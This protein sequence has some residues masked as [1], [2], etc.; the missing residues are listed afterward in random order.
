MGLGDTVTFGFLD[1]AGAWADTHV[2]AWLGNERA[3]FSHAENLRRNRA[4]LRAAEE[5]HFG[6]YTTGQVVG[7]FVPVLGWGGRAKAAYATAKAGRS[8]GLG[9][10]VVES[11]A[12]GALYGA[13]SADTDPD[14][15]WSE[16][17]HD[18]VR[19]AAIGG[20]FGAAGG[21]VLGTTVIP[22][23]RWGFDKATALVT[24]GKSPRL[25]FGLQPGKV[26][27]AADD[28]AENLAGARLARSRG[29]AESA[30]APSV[31]AGSA[32]V[33]AN[34]LTGHADDAL[35][36]GAVFTARELADGSASA[37]KTVLD[38]IAKLTPQEAR[39]AAQKL[40]NAMA[41]GDL[42]TDPHFRSLLGL[43]LESA[44]DDVAAALKGAEVFEDMTQ[45]LLQRAGMGSQSVKGME[46]RL[47]KQFGGELSESD[48]D[49]LVA[50]QTEANGAANVGSSVMALAGI[51][52][53]RATKELLP[54][55]MDG[56]AAAREALVE[57]LTSAIRIS[58]KGRFLVSS[59]GRNLGMLAH[60]R[61][62]PFTEVVG[63]RVEIESAEAI[64]AR[65]NE[66]LS[67]LDDAE[68]NELLS[69]VRDLSDLE[70]VQEVLLDAGAAESVS[71]FIKARNSVGLWIKSNSLTPMSGVVNVVGAIMHDLFRNGWARDFAA[72]TARLAGDVDVATSLSFQR[73]VAKAVHWQA[74]GAG[75][76][77]AINRLKWEWLDSVEKVAG[78]AGAQRV[79]LKASASRQ[80][81]VAGGYQPPELREFDRLRTLA[82][83]DVRGFNER[84][85]QRAEDGGGFASFVNGLER[86]YAAGINTFDALGTAT[87]RVVS[88]ALDDW[89]RNF[90]RVKEV[91]AASAAHAT[92]EAIEAGLNERQ[93]TEYVPKRA[94]EL[95]EL[96]PAD[97]L[98]EV[99]RKLVAGEDLGD[100]D[101]MLLRRDYEADKE[102]ERVLFMDGP[103]T[104]VGRAA[105]QAAKGADWVAG[106]MVLP[107]ILMTYI[108]TPTRIFERGLMS[109]TP[110]AHLAEESR[111]ALARGGVD[112]ALERARM[113]LGGMV[114]GIGM[115]AA[116]T[117]AITVTNGGYKNSRNLEGAPANRLNLPGGGYVELSR[118]D[119]FALT[120]A[121]GGVIGQAYRTYQEDGDEYGR[122]VAVAAAM[123]TAWGA[124]REAV[125]EKS[126]LTGAREL[127][128]AWFADEDATAASVYLDNAKQALTRLVPLA[129]TSR[130]INET[131]AGRATEAVTFMDQLFKVTPGMGLYLAPRIDALG[132]ETEGRDMGLAAGTTSDTDPLAKRVAALGIDIGNLRKSDP[133]GFDL[134][135]EELSELRRIRGKEAVNADGLTMPEALEALLD[136]PAFQA[137]QSRD[138]K[139]A[140]VGEV[141]RGFN[142]PARALFE[143]RN[144]AY[145]SDREARRSLK[146]YIAAGIEKHEARRQVRADVTGMGLPAPTRLA[147]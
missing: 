100:T 139:Q 84:L 53:A 127:V 92:R 128:K 33:R 46:A 24:R 124:V 145:L 49:R 96:P 111:A 23:A 94:A 110:W 35:E 55:V 113:D 26:G 65:V 125:L 140:E 37:R 89:G 5:D 134:T 119:P 121:L 114:M 27:A 16:A 6:A 50:A 54:R 132:N 97:I 40:E 141:L 79:A 98:E 61:R 123:Q 59:A 90:V 4:I 120:I 13:G 103:Q 58:A 108:R 51:R 73:E 129:G 88:G 2:P 39:V 118:L 9:R 86:A 7:G 43:D 116:A 109:Y 85:A 87:A 45:A 32:H 57:Q 1:E 77:A 93:M 29:P 138:E 72:Y 44:T 122:D 76:K 131:I 64:K 70:R 135:G 22:A 74:H 20:L 60:N 105:A 17:I 31:T 41:S 78:V 83:T 81:L 101:R 67:K 147:D 42:D 71:T 47:R 8:V 34:P 19:S 15:T 62:M 133:A 80:A 142:E 30:G 102:A 146:E 69:R 126:Y 68:L 66:A 137:L 10:I 48:L 115:I 112:A 136:D 95:A 63:D 144:Q 38:R 104:K 56:E 91:Y 75:I 106:G 36:A 130:Q 25:S 14:D 82:V 3:G 107:G 117:G 21:F 52:F 143:D 28:V 11:A 99:E 18:R 12:Q